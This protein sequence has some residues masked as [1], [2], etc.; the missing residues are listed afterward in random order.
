MTSIMTEVRPVFEFKDVRKSYY[1]RGQVVDALGPVSFD[2]RPG[3]FVALVGP[4]GC[5]KST[6]L[7]MA[8][9]LV[10]HTAG[11]VLFLGAPVKGVNKSVGYMTQH[12]GL[13]PWRNVR[14][15]AWLALELDRPRERATEAK[16]IDEI[17]DLVGLRAFAHSYPS[18]LSGGMRKRLSLARTLVTSADTLLMD[19]PFG[20]LDAQLRMVMHAEL[21]RIAKGKTVV[22]VTHDLHEALTI[23][24]RIIVFS[25]RPGLIRQVL[26]VDLPKPRDPFTI[27]FEPRFQE[28][29]SELWGVLRAEIIE[30]SEQ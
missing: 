22:F 1:R 4:S 29:H 5:G 10:D 3:E 15:N 8:A 2:I 28:L 21:L 12:D 13:L 11:E 9:G 30:E 23:A 17:L 20:A 7:N 25:A 24:D 6:A 26:E 18:E 27:Q 16:R 14:K 19:E